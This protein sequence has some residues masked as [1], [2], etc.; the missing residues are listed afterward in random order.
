MPP[1]RTKNAGKA[2]VKEQL[3]REMRRCRL[4]LFIQQF[5]KEAQERMNE[6]E[7]KLD[8]MLST[9]DKVFKVELMKML[10][11]LQNT[12]IGDLIR[13]EEIS[14][15]E[16]SIAMKNESLEMQQPLARVRSKRV[17]STDSKP[18][19]KSSSKTAKGGKGTKATRTL[20]SNS[21]G[22]PLLTGKRTRGHLTKAN[23]Q[24]IPTKPKLRSVVSA[25]DL[26][27]SMAGSAAHVTVTTAQGQTV[28]F[29]EETK[30]EI[31]LDLLDDVAIC[32]MQ[33]L[34]RLLDYLAS[35]SRCSQ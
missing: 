24:T 5:E 26:H 4:A 17:K 10:P 21:I 23:D 28:C 31:N 6:L 35:R 9:V 29:S 8:N 32:Q 27:C 12:L 14:A 15:S 13:E 1:R 2:H 11:S 20:G 7:A 25:G 19:Q 33:K 16:V 22:G 18:A 34:K 3:D 30:D